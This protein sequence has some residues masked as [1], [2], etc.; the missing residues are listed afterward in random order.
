M[1]AYVARYRAEK[2]GKSHGSKG[3]VEA[4]PQDQN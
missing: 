4:Y 3:R 2:G 1:L